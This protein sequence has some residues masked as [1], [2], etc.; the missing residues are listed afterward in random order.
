ML[1]WQ[2]SNPS[3]S[4]TIDDIKEK[5]E[6]DIHFIHYWIRIT[7]T[8][9]WE[10]NRR[11]GGALAMRQRRGLFT[12][13]L[14]GVKNGWAPTWTALKSM[15]PFTFISWESSKLGWTLQWRCDVLLL[16]LPVLLL[17]LWR[18]CWLVVVNAARWMH[19]VAACCWRETGCGCQWLMGKGGCGY[20]GCSGCWV[21]ARHGGSR[22]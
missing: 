19:Q 9:A 20:S 17:I 6:T 10:G 13:G 21:T 11:S 15:A 4:V 18:F 2:L 12:Y 14:N 3:C 5:S 1:L 16:L 7:V 8:Y 22:Q